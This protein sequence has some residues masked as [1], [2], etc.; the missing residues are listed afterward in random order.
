MALD[1]GWLLR[2]GEGNLVYN[3]S[4][5]S[6]YMVDIGNV[7]YQQ[8]VANWIKEPLIQYDFDGVFTDNGFNAVEKAYWWDV[9]GQTTQPINP[10]I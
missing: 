2:D 7:E 3:P 9:G 4:Y 1:N 5:P 6:I 10:R 8:W